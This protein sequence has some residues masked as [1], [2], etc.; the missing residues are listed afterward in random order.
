MHGYCISSELLVALLVA[1]AGN[2]GLA[3]VIVAESVVAARADFVVTPVLDSK[4]VEYCK[5]RQMPVVCGAMSPT[6]IAKAWASGATMVKVFPVRSLGASYIRDVLA[7][8]PHLALV[9]TGG[10][11]VN[12]VG[13]FFDAGAKPVGIGGSLIPQAA[14][15]SRD[16]AAIETVASEY[17]NAVRQA[18]G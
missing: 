15:K 4:V 7:P 9:P 8:M 11:D 1:V 3:A 5:A 17:A 6:E 16:W 12:N 13:S 14:V 18:K 2:D 10:V